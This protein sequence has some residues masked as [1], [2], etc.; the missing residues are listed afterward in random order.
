MG[1]HIFTHLD[2]NDKRRLKERGI[3]RRIQEGRT[4]LKRL[5]KAA[6]I[7]TECKIVAEKDL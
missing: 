1:N 3:R 7:S 6:Y 5:E 2:D 4:R